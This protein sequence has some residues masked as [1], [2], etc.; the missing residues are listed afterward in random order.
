MN[1]AVK[2]A[3]SGHALKEFEDEL[4]A[5]PTHPHLVGDGHTH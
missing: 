1:R 4:D 5:R 3:M 2:R